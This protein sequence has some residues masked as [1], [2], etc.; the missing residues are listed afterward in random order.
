MVYENL[1]LRNIYTI[2]HLKLTKLIIG[3]MFP[4]SLNHKYW[5]PY[6]YVKLIYRSTEYEHIK[7]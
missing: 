5:A 7:H 4:E 1:P 6:M 2:C 3:K